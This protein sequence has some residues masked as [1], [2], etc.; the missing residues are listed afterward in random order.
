MLDR[1]ASAY[2]GTTSVRDTGFGVAAGCGD[3]V[4]WGL[5]ARLGGAICNDEIC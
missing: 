1:G 3:Q 4:S 5:S 2:E